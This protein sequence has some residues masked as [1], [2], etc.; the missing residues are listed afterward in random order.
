MTKINK[1]NK[2][3]GR[4]VCVCV[5]FFLEVHE[6]LML[7]QRRHSKWQTKR[8]QILPAPRATENVA[9]RQVTKL[10]IGQGK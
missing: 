2:K 10:P 6:H 9:Q 5:F 8:Q 7:G 1:K 4:C 3:A